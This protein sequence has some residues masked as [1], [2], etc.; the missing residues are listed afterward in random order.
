MQFRRL[1]VANESKVS[2]QYLKRLILSEYDDVIVSE[3]ASGEE[4]LEK[5][6][7]HRFEAVLCAKEMVDISGAD[8][9]KRARDVASNPEMPILIVTSVHS[10]ENIQELLDE[11]IQHYLVSPFAPIELRAKIDAVCNP[12]QWRVSPRYSI[13]DTTARILIGS[14]ALD[15]V[16]VNIGYK[17]M[18]C[19][20][21]FGS[22]LWS[23]LVG[24]LEVE[25]QFDGAYDTQPP[26]PFEAHLDRLKVVEWD[27]AHAPRELQVALRMPFIS[28]TNREALKA[29]FTKFEVASRQW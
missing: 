16:V 13:P 12:R 24:K 25:V 29:V 15:V 22:E 17:G 26:E 23:A 2:R 27:S 6:K 7:H 18:L 21:P 10:G 9:L 14:E 1:L 20:V 5:L 28:E 11:G 4:A 8:M 3:A 19:H